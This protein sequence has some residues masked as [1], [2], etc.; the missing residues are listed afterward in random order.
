MGFCRP[1]A[2][3]GARRSSA[4]GDPVASP[5]LAAAMAG[6]RRPA[7]RGTFG[8]PSQCPAPSPSIRSACGCRL[9]G[10]VALRPAAVSNHR[11]C[12]SSACKQA[13]CPAAA[14]GRAFCL[15]WLAALCAPASF[16][17]MAHRA[18]PCR[19]TCTCLP[20]PAMAR[21]VLPCC[22]ACT[23]MPP[24]ARPTNSFVGATPLS[25]LLKATVWLAAVGMKP[26][27]AFLSC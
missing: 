5:V 13:C 24:A 10:P 25:G 8:P 18:A 2:G 14:L 23:H 22:S 4:T 6:A 9:C 7:D 19:S 3:S 1:A 11:R 26:V 15:L 20:G 12:Y 21:H 16:P 27:G 17:T